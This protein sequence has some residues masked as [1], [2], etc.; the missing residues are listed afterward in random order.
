[1]RI[2]RIFLVT[3]HSKIGNGHHS[4]SDQSYFLHARQ[5]TRKLETNATLRV[6]SPIFFVRASALENWKWT[7]LYER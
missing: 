3:L 2:I 6:T 7:P 1:M 4:A 5:C